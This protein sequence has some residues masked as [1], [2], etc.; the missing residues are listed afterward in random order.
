MDLVTL[1]KEGRVTCR[2]RWDL[3]GKLRKL[4]WMVKK[5]KGIVKYKNLN[6]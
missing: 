4:W 2:N 1:G 6:A 5:L 3:A